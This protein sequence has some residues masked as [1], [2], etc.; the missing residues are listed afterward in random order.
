MRRGRRYPRLAAGHFPNDAHGLARFDGTALYDLGPREGVHSE[1]NTYNYNL[2][3]NEVRGFLI[4]SALFWLEHFHAD[5]LRVDAVAAMLYRDYS[6]REGEW[7]P[8]RYGGRENLEAI[9]FLQELSR[10][11]AEEVPGAMLVAEESTAWPGVTRAADGRRTRFG[12]TVAEQ[13]SHA[14]VHRI[15]EQAPRLLCIPNLGNA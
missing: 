13:S 2:G 14:S 5:G 6:R 9:D 8:N 1:W 12:A 3:R 4:G 7:I 11:V 10:V 15:L